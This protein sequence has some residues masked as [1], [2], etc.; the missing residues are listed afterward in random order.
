MPNLNIY[1]FA[2]KF[3]VKQFL[4][5]THDT[6]GTRQTVRWPCEPIILSIGYLKSS[7][8]VELNRW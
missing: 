1:S 4:A 2:K 5:S 7:T 8:E 3:S 6:L